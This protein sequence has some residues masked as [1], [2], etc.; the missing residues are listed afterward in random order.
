MLAADLSRNQK[1]SNQ[2][3]ESGTEIGNGI[4]I[5]LSAEQLSAPA[6]SFTA[7]RLSAAAAV[8]DQLNAGCWLQNESAIRTSIPE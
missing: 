8:A 7:F 6:F 3:T 4:S 2:L 1:N 5:R